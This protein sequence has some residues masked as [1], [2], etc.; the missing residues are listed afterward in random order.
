M[1]SLWVESG[2][3][4]DYWFPL[5]FLEGKIYGMDVLTFEIKMQS[6]WQESSQEVRTSDCC[7]QTVYYDEEVAVMCQHKKIQNQFQKTKILQMR[8]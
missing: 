5:F 7:W 2:K 6:F 4:F 8:W 1:Y 3:D